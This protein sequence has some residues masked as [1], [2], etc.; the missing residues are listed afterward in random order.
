MKNIPVL[1]L[2][3]VAMVSAAPVLQ[4]SD[5]EI[6]PS[7]VYY[8]TIGKVQLT[9]VN[10]GTEIAKTATIYY[11]YSSDQRWSVYAGD[12]GA[13]S[14]AITT[15][16]FEVPTKVSTGIFTIDLDLYY[17][18]E[19]GDIAHSRTSIPITVSQHQILEVQTLS[20][21]KN[22]IGKGEKLT[23]ELELANTGGVM[24]NVIIKTADNSSFKLDGTTQFRVGDV[25]ANESKRVSV[26]LASSSDAKEGKYTIPLTITY[27]DALQ[28]E[29]SQTV[30]IGP[31]SVSDSSSML[32]LSGNP[33][34]GGEIGSTLEY[35]ITLENTGSTLQSAVLAIGENDVFTPIGTDTI[36][37]DDLQPGENRSET[38]YLG[39]DGSTASGYY[40][41]PLTIK[42]NG[43]SIGHITGIFVQATP[44]VILTSET[45]SSDTG[46][47]TTIRIANSGNTI[48]R[49]LYVSAE[50]APGI[51]ITGQKDKFIGTLNVDDFATFQISVRTTQPS[52]KIPVKITF[53]DNDNAEHTL[54]KE[55]DVATDSLFRARA[56]TGGFQRSGPG[57]SMATGGGP[58]NI[59][60]YVGA[61]IFIIVALYFGYKKYLAG[62]KSG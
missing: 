24:K 60:L 41:L 56:S 48:I 15:I 38:I 47:Q 31:V 36:Y 32:R 2:I 8:G 53:K 21:S 25:A 39:V 54:I 28:N 19:G 44:A 11:T 9:V 5:Y 30:N 13:G 46:L 50:T 52:G 61:G 12:I 22:N 16:P 58:L 55:I 45:E 18:N 27:N 14:E 7:N 49:S 57:G 20:L 51:E 59:L 3:F 17:F 6:F 43:D 29:I 4:I 42:T 62:K 33:I 34:S 10:G 40:A 37:F 35:Q 1:L 23:A 26:T